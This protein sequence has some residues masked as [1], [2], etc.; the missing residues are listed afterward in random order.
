MCYNRELNP[1]SFCLSWNGFNFF[2][3]LKMVL[4]GIGFL[5]DG[6]F[7][8]S[9]WKMS[10]HCF[11]VS[12]VFDKMLP[13]VENSLYV[14][15]HSACFK[16]LSV[17]SFTLICLVWISL[18]WSD[19]EFIEILGST[20][21]NRLEALTILLL[22]IP[23]YPFLFLLR[24]PLCVSW[25][26]WWYPTSLR[27]LFMC[28]HLFFLLLLI[29]HNVSWLIFKLTDSS[30]SSH[31][32]LSLCSKLSLLL[33]VLL[34]FKFSIWIFIYILYLVRYHFRTSL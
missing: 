25:Y 1:L 4:I 10:S 23:V 28:R 27:A 16:I 9:V 12:M 22:Q 26:A 8:F 34:N 24:L 15:T 14:M 11:L 29:L 21:F 31:M 5:V 18:S 30:A 17:D 6:L 32:L 3:I 19:L 33:I 20:L 7:S 2:S 13:V